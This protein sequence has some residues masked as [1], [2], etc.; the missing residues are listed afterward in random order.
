MGPQTVF[1]QFF[2]QDSAKPP[3]QDTLPTEIDTIGPIGTS[4]YESE[5]S[6]GIGDKFPFTQP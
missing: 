2:A 4:S 6:R 5:E 1:S 3:F